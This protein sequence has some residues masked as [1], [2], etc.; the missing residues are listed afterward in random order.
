[1]VNQNAGQKY[2][3]KIRDILAQKNMLPA[4]L[5]HNDAGFVHHGQDYY[6]EVKNRTAP[7]Y[8]Q[9]RIRW[10]NTNAWQWSKPDQITALYDA[11]GVINYIDPQFSPKRYTVVPATKITDA[12]VSYD[13]RHF[14][15]SGIILP[16]IDALYDY[17]E[18]KQCFYIQREG[19]G[20]F[21]LRTD[22]ASIGAPQ[23]APELTLRLRAKRHH[24]T[25]AYNYSFFAVIQIA[26]YHFKSIYDIEG[27]T[28]PF[29]PI[30]PQN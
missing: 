18:R 22:A 6:L 1:M 7:D 11:L 14:E 8:G 5:N 19:Y 29:P 20:F 12:D 9:K 25:P 28:G 27:K 10:D 13:Q 3:E 21:C 30:V 15:K 2:E 17:Y 23:F 16:S 24:S 4:N 26:P